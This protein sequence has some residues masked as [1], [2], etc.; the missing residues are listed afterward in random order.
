MANEGNLAAWLA[1]LVIDLDRTLI[2]RDDQCQGKTSVS[3]I[4]SINLMRLIPACTT[5]PEI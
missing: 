2:K 5:A 1:L 3:R 4:K